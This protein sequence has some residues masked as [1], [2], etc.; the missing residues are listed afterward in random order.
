MP[1]M[2]SRERITAALNFDQVD[3]IPFVPLI[4]D[5]TLR[6]MPNEVFP[7]GVRN[8]ETSG[9]IGVS[10]YLDL[11]LLIRHIYA[12]KPV[13]LSV[14]HLG[15][16][17]SFD[18]SIKSAT[19]FNEK[20]CLVETVE[21]PVGSIEGQWQF[22]DRVGN[23]PHAV[24]HAVNNKQELDVF[25]YLSEH[26]RTDAWVPDFQGYIRYD[27]LIGDDGIATSSISNTPFMYLIEMVWGLENTYYLLQDYPGIVEEI[28]YNLS[29][30][31]LRYVELMADSPAEVIIQ[32]E[33]T[34]STLLSP[35]V[36][37][38]YCLPLL[39]QCG[40]TLK[41]AGKTFLVHMCGTLQAFVDDI[42]V[43]DFHGI[44]D[45]TPHPTGD[46]PLA[47]AADR[48][49]GKIVIGGID[50]NTF[51]CEDE[52]RVREEVTEI[53][54]GIKPYRGVLLGSADSTPRGT[55]VQNFRVMRELV[56]AEGA[57]I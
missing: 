23:I 45:I 3:K 40:R 27:N 43:S 12:V 15:M 28:L 50:P 44:C 10:R 5:Y 31:L 47:E 36:F 25:R 11:D 56:N 51:V 33:N 34:S 29:D 35:E 24:K 20:G 52:V 4:A 30:S 38:K 14:P 26:I 1:G 22:T 6:D 7:N 13:E 16:M 37:C 41:Q 18:S 8:L 39:N 21:T 48:L 54:R 2:S 9:I 57:Y 32:Y 17:G 55:P 42:K 53:I 19:S 49:D 46:L